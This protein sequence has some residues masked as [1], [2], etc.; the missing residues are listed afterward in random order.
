MLK[1]GAAVQRV[2]E[3]LR[4]AI[5]AACVA[6]GEALWTN[7]YR[8]A[9]QACGAESENEDARLYA[10][11]IAQFEHCAKAEARVDRLIAALVFAVRSVPSHP[12][13]RRGKTARKRPIVS[14]RA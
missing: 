3:N 5:Q 11:E 9:R 7:G 13:G 6:R 14:T 1:T 8:A 4:R 10:K 12:K 2:R